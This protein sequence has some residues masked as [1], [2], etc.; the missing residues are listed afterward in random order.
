[1]RRESITSFMAQPGK[2]VTKVS[3]EPRR[4]GSPSPR[5]PFWIQWS[6]KASWIG[7]REIGGLSEKDSRR[8]DIGYFPF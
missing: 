7:A 6:R 3:D 5:T 1:M 8:A 4:R 2:Q